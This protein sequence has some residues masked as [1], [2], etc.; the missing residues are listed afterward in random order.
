MKHRLDL[1]TWLRKDHFHF[2]S[3]FEE[4]FF[5]V[6]VTIDCTQAYKAAKESGCSFFLFYL[7]KSLL[8]ANQIEP[9]RYRI[10]NSEMSEVM[11]Y[12]VVNASSTINRANGTF[13]FAYM[14]YYQKQ[15]EFFLHAQKEIERFQST[16]GLVPAVSGENVIHYSSIP[17]INFVTV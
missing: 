7:H 4:P 12:D 13:G 6:C 15:E 16:T 10:E 1:D 5:G 17:W 9:F 8:A 2:F 11:V 14:E 3:Q